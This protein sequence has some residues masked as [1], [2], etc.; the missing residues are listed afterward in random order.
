MAA[1]FMIADTKEA[2]VE[3]REALFR[4]DEATKAEYRRFGR[5]TSDSNHTHLQVSLDRTHGTPAPR[6]TE[7][8]QTQGDGG[9]TSHTE[10]FGKIAESFEEKIQ[11]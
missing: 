7:M 10:I 8:M 2:D 3:R 9:D 5:E 6:C 4:S 1:G 11:P